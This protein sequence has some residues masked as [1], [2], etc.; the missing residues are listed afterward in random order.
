MRSRSL[1]LAALT[2][3]A[4]ALPTAVFAGSDRSARQE[5]VVKL[6]SV[7]GYQDSYPPQLGGGQAWYPACMALNIGNNLLDA[8][9]KP[10]VTLF[11]N[12]DAVFLADASNP[13][14]GSQT[15]MG[16]ATVEDALEQFIAGGGKVV[17]CPGCAARAGLGAGDL[18]EGTTLGSMES[19]EAL[20]LRADKVIDY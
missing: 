15:C 8:R 12:L 10:R 6:D 18:R 13:L 9:K 1:A 4:L 5:I 3:A 19:I 14:I 17:V 7:E 16:T 20:F 2:L 11:L